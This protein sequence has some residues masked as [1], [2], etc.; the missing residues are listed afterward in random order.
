MFKKFLITTIILTMMASNA[1]AALYSDLQL[2]TRASAMGSSFVSVARDADAVYWNP[3][4]LGLSKKS[5]VMFMYSDVFGLGIN[6]SYIAYSQPLGTFGLG[7]GWLRHSAD[8]QEG[9]AAT[10]K[11]NKWVDDMYSISLG[12]KARDNLY[13]G[14]N[15]K[16]FKVKTSTTSTDNI[17]TSGTGFDLGILATNLYTYDK[18]GISDVNLGFTVRN[19]ASDLSGENVD[20]SYKLGFST[21]IYEDFIFAIGVDIDKENDKQETKMK[22]NTGLEYGYNNSLFWRVG[23]NSGNFTTGF[24]IVVKERLSLD[25]TFEQGLFDL[26]KDNH[27]FSLSFWF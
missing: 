12:T 18:W 3:G 21:K 16:R 11:S 6:Q 24:G 17:G 8:L 22:L 7:V 25:Y 10:A 9:F 20:P 15:L 23:L 19:L 5:N 4:A 26:G 2:G 27:R 13:A 14:L 1:F